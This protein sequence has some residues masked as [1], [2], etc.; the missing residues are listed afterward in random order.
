MTAGIFEEEEEMKEVNG[1]FVTVRDRREA[2]RGRDRPT[3]GK[4]DCVSGLFASMPQPFGDLLQAH[5]KM[6]VDVVNSTFFLD[7]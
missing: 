6:M 1:Y 2:R 4:S 3:F 5:E 7:D